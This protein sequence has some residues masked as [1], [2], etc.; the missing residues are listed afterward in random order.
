MFTCGTWRSHLQSRFPGQVR[1][2]T[3]VTLGFL[4]GF[5]VNDPEHDPACVQH[6]EEEDPHDQTRQRGLR[7]HLTAS[8]TAHT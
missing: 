1:R 6:I 7:K 8:I 5:G 3:A 2:D 4:A